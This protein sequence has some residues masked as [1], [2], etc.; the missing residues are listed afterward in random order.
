M[1]SP[2]AD[3]YAPQ[4]FVSK[5]LSGHPA[6]VCVE[7][8]DQRRTRG[9]LSIGDFLAVEVERCRRQYLYPGTAERS[10]AK[11][12]SWLPWLSLAGPILLPILLLQR[13]SLPTVPS[14]AGEQEDPSF[15]FARAFLEAE[16]DRWL[17]QYR[18]E[19]GDQRFIGIS[20]ADASKAA[21]G[22]TKAHRWKVDGGF[23]TD[24]TPTFLAGFCSLAPFLEHVDSLRLGD[25]QVHEWWGNR[26]CKLMKEIQ[27]ED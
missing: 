2:L 5:E 18:R 21:W 22:M 3:L 16:A 20:I 14:M 23:N 27:E 26:F 10:A 19:S 7:A 11:T 9:L 13:A 6:D 8:L 12:A 25:E 15:H 17:T 4:C 24:G 1:S